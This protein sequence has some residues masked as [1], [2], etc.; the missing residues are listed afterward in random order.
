MFNS[1]KA[2]LELWI[3]VFLLTTI[4]ILDTEQP[5]GVLRPTRPVLLTSLS[6]R[7]GLASKTA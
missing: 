1:F 4:S 7:K 2:S 6:A 5:Q 3:F